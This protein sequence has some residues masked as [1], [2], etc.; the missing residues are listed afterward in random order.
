[1]IGAPKSGTVL[2]RIVRVFSWN[3]TNH[4]LRGSAISGPAGT[5]S[6]GTSVSMS[7][8]G[9]VL[10]VGAPL[11]DAGTGGTNANKGL[12]RVYSWDGTNYIQKGNNIVGENG[13]DFV[14]QSVS[15]SSNG[16]VFAV[17]SPGVNSG[18][19][20]SADKGKVSMYTLN[21]SSYL[22]RGEIIGTNANDKPGT[23]VSV[24]YDGSVLAIG[25]PG[26]FTATGLVRVYSWNGNNYIQRGSEIT[27]EASGDESGKSVACGSNQSTLK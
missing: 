10:A 26:T 23:S 24:S 13:D 8:V 1:V 21:S 2:D 15:V 4:V 14:G 5:E 20:T 17:G 9:Q 16:D 3:G 6:F 18:S 22:L 11:Y 25:A 7:Y 27:G 12:A 19:G